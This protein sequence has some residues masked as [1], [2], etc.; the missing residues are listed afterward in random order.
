ML[1]G[2]SLNFVDWVPYTWC[3][4]NF[5]TLNIEYFGT[6]EIF[7]LELKIVLKEREK[8]EKSNCLLFVLL[9]FIRN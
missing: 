4:Y 1:C 7:N 3:K 5:F 8:K 6:C 9:V 2:R